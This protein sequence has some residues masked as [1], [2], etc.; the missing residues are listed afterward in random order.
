MRRYN[1]Q[2]ETVHIMLMAHVS[3]IAHRIRIHLE[4]GNI[5][6][7]TPPYPRRR[8]LRGSREYYPPKN[9]NF[10]I[11]KNN[12]R[13]WACGRRE[14]SSS[15]RVSCVGR[16]NYQFK[17]IVKVSGHVL[18]VFERMILKYWYV[19]CLV[20]IFEIFF[21]TFSR[22]LWKKS[23]WPLQERTNN[24]TTPRFFLI[25]LC[26]FLCFF[27]TCPYNFDVL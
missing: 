18:C 21:S 15:F 13:R 14:G 2:Q 4:C 10:I 25:C 26:S 3:Q 23:K 20:D 7:H 12:W 8:S 9:V 22:S 5:R 19:Y 17:L 1:F 16:N 6:K 24:L 11:G 27:V